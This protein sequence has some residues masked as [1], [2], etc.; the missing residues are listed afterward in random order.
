MVSLYEHNARPTT[1]EIPDKL[2]SPQGVDMTRPRP[3]SPLR[4]N[5]L[6]KFSGK[7]SKCCAKASLA[8]GQSSTIHLQ[9]SGMKLFDRP[10]S[11]PGSINGRD[12]IRYANSNRTATPCINSE[13]KKWKD[14]TSTLCRCQ[15]EVATGKWRPKEF[16]WVA[17]AQQNRIL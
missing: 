16:P 8:K 12:E 4:R 11:L 13:P 10:I 15:V 14:M 7:P 17:Q 5:W 1:L 6:S 9:V 2:P 3:S